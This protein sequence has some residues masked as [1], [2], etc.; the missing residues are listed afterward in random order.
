M[1]LLMTKESA[2]V[3]GDFVVGQIR[4]ESATT[5]KVLAAVPDGNCEYKPSEKCMPGLKLAAH[6]AGAEVFFL[7]G[8]LEG[9]FKGGED[10][11]LKTPAE[12]V[13]FYDQHVP[14]LLDK[15][16]QLSGEQ[17]TRVLKFAIFEL[18]AIDFLTIS[19]KHTIHHRGQLS[20]YLRPMGG[21]VPSIYGPSA[22]EQVTGAGA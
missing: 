22:D 2:K 20:A 10:P 19:L 21:R 8:V 16:A 6:I 13:A 12:I 18:P 3:L 14:A 15:A 17:L 4:Q 9:E 11:K 5:R 1:L 7:R